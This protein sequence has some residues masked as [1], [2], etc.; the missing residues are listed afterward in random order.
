MGQRTG[1]HALKH[2]DHAGCMTGRPW[3]GQEV[4]PVCTMTGSG[5]WYCATVLDI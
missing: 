4:H 1:L 2:S 5:N 3:N